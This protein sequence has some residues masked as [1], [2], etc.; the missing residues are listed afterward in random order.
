MVEELRSK[1]ELE[2]FIKSNRI[3]VVAIV[4]DPTSKNYVR[5]LLDKLEEKS[6]N[7]IRSGIVYPCNIDEVNRD[8]VIRMYIDSNMVFEQ[9][10]IFWKQDLDYE[11]LRRGIKDV[12]KKHNFKTLF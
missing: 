6:R 2:R 8:I 9:Q 4:S 7:L 5:K 3:A 1:E 10:G 11:A 12:L